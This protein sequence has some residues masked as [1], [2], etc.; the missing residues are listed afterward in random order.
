MVKWDFGFSLLL[1]F[2]EMF[3]NFRNF[4]QGEISCEQLKVLY[5]HN[6]YIQRLNP[7]LD[8]LTHLTHLYLQWNRIRQFENLNRLTNLRKL[9]LS[10]NEISHLDGIDNLNFLTEL[11]LEYQRLQPN[12]EFTFDV[13]SLI[14]ISASFL[15]FIE[16]N[17]FFSIIIVFGYF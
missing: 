10:Y 7:N 13:N 2:L 5:L 11:H 9:Y 16:Y 8:Q 15:S 14:G 12:T 3:E 17:V 4:F 1:F 6:N